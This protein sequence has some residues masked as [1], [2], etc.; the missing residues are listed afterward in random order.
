MTW[1]V[2]LA[3]TGALPSIAVLVAVRSFRRST[4]PLARGG[5]VLIIGLV[6]LLS[7]ST[8]AH[9]AP[10]DDFFSWLGGSLVLGPLFY[11][12]GRLLGRAARDSAAGGQ[13]SMSSQTDHEGALPF[14]QG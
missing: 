5:H 14:R 10:P 2:W 11:L 8:G 1:S 4:D 13:D 12:L 3:L 9:L 6:V 7:L